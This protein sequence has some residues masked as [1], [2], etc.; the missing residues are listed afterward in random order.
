MADTVGVWAIG[1]EVETV[2]QTP[3]IDPWQTLPHT[4]TMTLHWPEGT[5]DGLEA[6]GMCVCVWVEEGRKKGRGRGRM[7]VWVRGK[8]GNEEEQEEVKCMDKGK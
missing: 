7:D 8:K 1:R 6:G 5:R 2:L 4:Y 3:L